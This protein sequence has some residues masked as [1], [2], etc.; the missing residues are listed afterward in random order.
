MVHATGDKPP[1]VTRIS[2]S[3]DAAAPRHARSRRQEFRLQISRN[4]RPAP[5]SDG[6]SP[7]TVSAMHA[8]LE[9]L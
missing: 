8:K 1:P 2:S 9:Q 3:E 4:G 5:D 7:D 6:R